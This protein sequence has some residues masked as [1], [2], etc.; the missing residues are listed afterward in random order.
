MDP[1]IVFPVSRE[2]CDAD[3]KAHAYT[4]E[5]ARSSKAANRPINRQLSES[6]KQ[7]VSP[8]RKRWFWHYKN[9]LPSLTQFGQERAGQGKILTWSQNEHIKFTQWLERSYDIDQSHNIYLGHATRH[10]RDHCR[11]HQPR[12]QKR[13]WGTTVSF[14]QIHW[15]MLAS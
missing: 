14:S 15:V 10:C 13:N 6:R 11:L 3:L 4:H 9:K 2:Q 8:P 1:W 7:M 12:I 5:L